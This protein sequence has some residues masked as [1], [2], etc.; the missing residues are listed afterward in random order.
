MFTLLPYIVVAVLATAAVL[1]HGFD[2]SLT[3]RVGLSLMAIGSSLKVASIAAA[4]TGANQSCTILAYGVAVFFVGT[5][6]ELKR[7]KML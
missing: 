3:Q 5:V 2:D 1:H 4:Q 6:F 7:L